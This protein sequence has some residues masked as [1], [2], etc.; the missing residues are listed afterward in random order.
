MILQEMAQTLSDAM[1][2]CCTLGVK[3]IEH[4]HKA[5]NEPNCPAT[6]HWL[7]EMQNWFND[8]KNIK[9][10]TTNKPLLNRQ[11]NDWFFTATS[12]PE[13]IVDMDLDEQIIYD[14]FC[15][16]LLNNLDVKIT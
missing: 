12:F 10:K 2:R 8:V 9:L 11:I 6:N 14:K 1:D 4:F 7:K 16:L 3:F 13:D 15:T 5:Y